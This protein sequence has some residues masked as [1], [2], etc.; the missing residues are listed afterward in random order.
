MFGGVGGRVL[1][2]LRGGEQAAPIPTY[3]YSSRG[4][5]NKKV[6]YVLSLE[7]SRET[8]IQRTAEGKKN[9]APMAV[10][11]LNGEH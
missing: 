3:Y 6:S 4:T 8:L 1:S 9:V 7:S 5:F 2:S 10:R 11:E